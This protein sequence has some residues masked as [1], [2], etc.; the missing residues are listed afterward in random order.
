VESSFARFGAREPP[1]DR[2]DSLVA[3]GGVGLNADLKPEDVGIAMASAPPRLP[4]PAR[5]GPLG[6][7]WDLLPQTRAEAEGLAALFEEVFDRAAVVLTGSAATKRALRERAPSARFLH[8]ATHGY[9]APDSVRSL[10]DRAGAPIRVSPAAAAVPSSPGLWTPLGASETATGLAP[11]TLCGLALA[12]A[13]RGTDPLGRVPGILTAE[14]LARFDLSGCE[15][16]VLSACDTNVGATRAGQGISSLRAA[17]HAAGARTAIT[18]LWK[19]DD[20]ATRALFADFYARIW[21][22]HEPKAEALWSAMMALKRAGRP[23][24]DWAAWVMTGDPR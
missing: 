12:G 11:M 3:V 19:V 13:N 15:L 9:F 10:S 2:G 16:A 18:S 14:E 8:V 24:R 6:T 22:H 5:A 17:L 23:T 20:E 7:H 21:V 1:R 4:G